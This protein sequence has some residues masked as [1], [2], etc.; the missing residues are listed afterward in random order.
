MKL[1]LSSFCGFASLTSKYDLSNDDDEESK[2]QQRNIPRTSRFG[3]SRNHF[4]STPS[5]HC[6]T[7]MKVCGAARLL[8][9]FFVVKKERRNMQMK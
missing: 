1:V 2:V 7:G 6:P 8:K 4:L 9:L 3:H 5:Y